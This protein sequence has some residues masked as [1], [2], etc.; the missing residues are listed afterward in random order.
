[1][2]FI[3]SAFIYFGAE[4]CFNLYVRFRHRS[5]VSKNKEEKDFEE[6]K[7]LWYSFLREWIC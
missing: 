3:P 5:A 2:R 7:D 4:L 1:M 6:E